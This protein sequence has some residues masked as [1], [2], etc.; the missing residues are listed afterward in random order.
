MLAVA[1]HPVKCVSAKSLGEECLALE[2]SS[3]QFINPCR[4]CRQNR[5]L[6]CDTSG[7]STTCVLFKAAAVPPQ[8]TL[9]SQ[10]EGVTWGNYFPLQRGAAASSP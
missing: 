2:F 7:A 6:L 8:R 4:L 5:E 3:E 10:R 9:L 1:Y